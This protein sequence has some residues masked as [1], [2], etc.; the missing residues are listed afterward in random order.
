MSDLEFKKILTPQELKASQ[1]ELEISRQKLIS[2]QVD[3]S[4][5]EFANLLRS[6]TNTIIEAVESN[7]FDVDPFAYCRFKYKTGELEL[8]KPLLVESFARKG[9]RLLVGD[10]TIEWVFLETGEKTAT[11]CIRKKTTNIEMFEN[12]QDLIMFC[13]DAL[14]DMIIEPVH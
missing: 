2:I 12:L 6:C 9:W 1:R 11:C 7:N 14:K 13:L 4:S 8:V 5:P 10:S 3:A